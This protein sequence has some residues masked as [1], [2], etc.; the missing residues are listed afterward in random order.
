MSIPD[1]TS[2][3]TVRA[4]FEE[5]GLQPRKQLG[6]NFLI[7]ANIVRKIAAFVDVRPGDAVIE[8]GPGAGALTH[9]LA[10]SGADLVA[11]EVDRGLAAM[12]NGLFQPLPDVKILHQ[13]I[14]KVTWADLILRFFPASASI[15]LVS[16]L[17]YVI[18]GPFIYALLKESFPFE[19][20][21][22]M[23]QKEVAHRLVADPG[24][25]DYGGLSVLCQYYTTGKILFDVS[26][27]VFWPRPKVGSAVL[28]LEPKRRELA[29]KEEEQL[30]FLVQGV[31]QQRRKTML[32]SLLRLLPHPRDLIIALMEEAQVDPAIRPEQL[33]VGQF[34]KLAQITYNYSS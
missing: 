1:L 18:S 27:N 29:M 2:P 8:I 19:S 34:A 6:Q 25:T 11:V 13:D 28:K 31:F 10:L 3:R 26:H 9:A 12:L 16:N 22:L 33:N 30:W 7:D 15:K 14:L 20:A 32:N 5:Y 23:L 4:L 21:V 24:D 17:P